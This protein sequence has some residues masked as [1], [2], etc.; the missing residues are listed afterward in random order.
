MKNKH[1]NRSPFLSK[2]GLGVI[3]L[4]LILAQ[5]ALF[6]ISWLLSATRQEGVH[7][8]L[9]SEGIRWFFGSFILVMASP[10]LV[11]LIL[12]LIAL[13]SLQKSGL[14]SCLLRRPWHLTYR[15]RIALRAT[16]FVM[17]VYLVVICLLTMLPH[18]ILLSVTGH[19]FPSPF[20]H[21]L[22]PIIAFGIS[23]LSIV[24][25]MMSGRLHSLSDILE[26][27]SCGIS[28]GAS[29]IVIY[30]FAMQLIASIWFVFG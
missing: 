11:W 14:L 16:A 19:L 4:I 6:V 18:A 17:I 29:Y 24:F 8:L 30:I 21:S 28:Y 1:N 25:G 9:S 27:L 2:E 22:I 10:L 3:G 7:S 23:I 20:S 13:G 26:S 5:M 15:E 12:C